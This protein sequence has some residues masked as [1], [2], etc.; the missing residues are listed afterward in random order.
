MLHRP[1]PVAVAVALRRVSYWV[2]WLVQSF[3]MRTGAIANIIANDTVA[4]IYMASDI[5]VSGA[6]IPHVAGT[7]TGRGAVKAIVISIADGTIT[8]VILF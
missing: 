7:A 8:R 3:M 2:L 4:I 6:V 5:I 1:K